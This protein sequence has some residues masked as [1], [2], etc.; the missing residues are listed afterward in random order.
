[1]NQ[2]EDNVRAIY[3]SAFVATIVMLVIIPLQRL[4]FVL[5]P[6][7]SSTPEWFALL[8]ARPIVGMFHTDFFLMVNNALIV[9]IYLAFWHS[10]KHL[11]RGLLQK[12]FVLGLIGIAAYISSTKTFELL[13]LAGYRFRR[14]LRPERDNPGHRRGSHAEG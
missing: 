4:A 1:M 13:R 9:L 6:M 11:N 8:Q 12:A 2:Q 3:V 14:V 10:L 7:P 5:F